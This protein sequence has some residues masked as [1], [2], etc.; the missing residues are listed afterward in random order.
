MILPN[1][2]L[3]LCQKANHL[4]ERLHAVHLAILPHDGEAAVTASKARPLTSPGTPDV[5]T[6]E[7][8]EAC[9]ST[10]PDGDEW[11]YA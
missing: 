1:R 3:T 11:A 7:M 9:A 10:D 8:R 2:L 4:F 6:P 5:A